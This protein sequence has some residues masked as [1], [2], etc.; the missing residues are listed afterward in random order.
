MS[1]ESVH[2]DEFGTISFS[3]LDTSGEFFKFEQ[4]QDSNLIFVTVFDANGRPIAKR[5]INADKDDNKDIIELYMSLI[6][7][8]QKL[9]QDQ[10]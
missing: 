2:F 5:I 4:E 8:R 7:E 6:E 1:G 10:T 9:G 3:I